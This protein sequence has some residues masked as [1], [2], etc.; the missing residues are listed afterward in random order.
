M[1]QE[2]LNQ[3]IMAAHDVNDTT[4]LGIL[5]LKAG[6]FFIANGDL[7][8]ISQAGKNY[9]NFSSGDYFGEMSLILNEKRTA[10][11]VTVSFCDIFCLDK[12]DYIRIKKEYPQFRV[13]LEHASSKQSEKRFES[14]MDQIIL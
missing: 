14:I 10:S 8:V 4:T 6:K 1:N 13:I 11:V 7:K 2:A 3:K 12:E 5:Y 9:N